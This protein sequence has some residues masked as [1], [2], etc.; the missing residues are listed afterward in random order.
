M[1]NPVGIRYRLVELWTLVT[2]TNQQQ[3]LCI[4][5]GTLLGFLPNED[6]NYCN[7]PDQLLGGTIREGLGAT[8]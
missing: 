6:P 5:T 7:E 1:T 4:A 8:E 2:N 3:Q